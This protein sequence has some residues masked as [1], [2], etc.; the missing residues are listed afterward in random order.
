MKTIL[1]L[2]ISFIASYAQASCD[3][4]KIKVHSGDLIKDFVGKK[5]VQYYP[6]LKD[7]KSEFPKT[8]SIHVDST[9]CLNHTA[10]LF[11]HLS[12]GQRKFHY[13]H[14]AG[15]KN[16]HHN[17]HDHH[18]KKE[19]TGAHTINSEFLK[20]SSF[21]VK[22]KIV[23]NNFVIKDVPHRVFYKDIDEKNWYN[24]VKYT[25]NVYNE[26]GKKVDSKEIILDSPL[27]H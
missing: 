17:D 22:K 8:V 7:F 9:K 26:V 1:V 14:S 12:K 19:I 23:S 6:E 25:L 15:E 5:L 20:S 24:K 11:V 4:K 10:H 13:E 2:L 18:G 27:I 16:H 3:I 21:K